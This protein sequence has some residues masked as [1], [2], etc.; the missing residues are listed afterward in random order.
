VKTCSGGLCFEPPSAAVFRHRFG[1]YTR[2]RRLM[3]RRRA[4]AAEE[5][6][7]DGEL[8]GGDRSRKPT[9][10]FP[11]GWELAGIDMLD[12]LELGLTTGNAAPCQHGAIREKR[13]PR[14]N[15][16]RAGLP[17]AGQLDGPA[18]LCGMMSH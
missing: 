14:R 17:R 13:E 5:N 9:R 10:A 18:K 16:V 3:P 12:V 1:T 11:S 2:S 7:E 4:A 15:S 8:F 6:E